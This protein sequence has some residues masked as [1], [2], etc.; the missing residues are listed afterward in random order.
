MDNKKLGHSSNQTSNPSLL[1]VAEPRQPSQGFLFFILPIL[2]K[3]KKN[4]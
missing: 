2:K 3:K 4:L 1:S